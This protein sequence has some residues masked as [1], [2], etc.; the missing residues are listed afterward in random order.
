MNP[1]KNIAAS[2]LARLKNLA[3]E[4][5]REY[6]FLVNLYCRERFLYRLGLSEYK[7]NLILKGG[8]LILG[9]SGLLERPTKDIDVSGRGI[10]ND[11][12]SL[13][14]IIAEISAIEVDDGVRFDCGEI[15]GEEITKQRDYPGIRLRFKAFIGTAEYTMQIDL[16]F[17]DP[18]IPGPVELEYWTLLDFPP[19]TIMAYPYSSVVAEKFETMCDLGAA[20]SRMQDF[21]D[22]YFLAQTYEFEMEILEKAIQETFANRST[23]LS[24]DNPIFD[25]SLIDEAELQARWTAYLKRVGAESVPEEFSRIIEDIVSFLEPV[26]RSA[27]EGSK[28]TLNWDPQISEWRKRK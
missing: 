7:D 22:V 10:P 26:L 13:M 8:L 24:V 2:V 18:I 11:I 27:I 21:Y 17:G 19:P 4:Q 25:G 15:N 28:Q 23:R 12:Q 1:V 9:P 3:R 5:R 20:N 6:N 16:G 14:K